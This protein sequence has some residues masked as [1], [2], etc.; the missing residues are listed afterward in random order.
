MQVK[1]TSN[2]K[3]NSVSV[4][5]KCQN[6][7]NEVQQYLDLMKHFLPNLKALT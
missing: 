4:F 1:I 6:I 2:V 7:H 3:R 5:N